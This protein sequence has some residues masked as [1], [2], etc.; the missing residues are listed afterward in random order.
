MTI[1]WYPAAT[2]TASRCGKTTRRGTGT[3]PPPS[4][5]TRPRYVPVVCVWHSSRVVVDA[6]VQVK[7]YPRVCGVVVVVGGVAV[8]LASF[9]HFLVHPSSPRGVRCRCGAHRLRPLA[10]A[11]LRAATTAAWL[12]GTMASRV[13]LVCRPSVGGPPAS[14]LATTL[15]P[16]TWPVL[17][18][19]VPQALVLP[20]VPAVC[21]GWTGPICHSHTHVCCVVQWFVRPAVALHTC[22]LPSMHL[23]CLLKHVA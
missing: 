3:A 12:C 7:Q 19:L 2:T 14:S 10:P 9:L 6:S 16:C 23:P 13:A 15:A 8:A 1:P 21:G 4:P 22:P 18:S 17:V 11:S 5:P 20:A